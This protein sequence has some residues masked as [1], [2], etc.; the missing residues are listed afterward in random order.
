MKR[1]LKEAAVKRYDHICNCW[2]EDP[3]NFLSNPV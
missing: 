3:N 2:A 1:T